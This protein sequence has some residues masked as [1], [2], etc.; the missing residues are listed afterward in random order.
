MAS[1]ENLGTTIGQLKRA[2]IDA[3]MVSDYGGFAG[4]MWTIESDKYT[5]GGKAQVTRPG[6]NGEG[7]GD[8]SG[9]WDWLIGGG[10]DEEFTG[11]FNDIRTRIDDAVDHWTANLPVVSELK[12][13]GDKAHEAMMKLGI[14]PSQTGGTVNATGPIGGYLNLIAEGL[15]EMS[16][17][18]IEAFKGKFLSQL[19]RVIANQY[20]MTVPI[21]GALRAQENL[22]TEA[23]KDIANIVQE[24]LDAMNAVVAGSGPNWELL[25]TVVGVAAKGAG[26]FA[27]GGLKAATEVTGL[28]V[29]VLT[30]PGN[31]NKDSQASA[32][33]T[34]ESVLTALESSVKELSDRIG[35]EEKD[36][37]KNLD[38]N[39]TAFENQLSGYDIN[40]TDATLDV[41][42]A[43]GPGVD[44]VI[45]SKALVKGIT[46]THMP[47][48]ADELKAAASSLW[49]AQTSGTALNRPEGIGV[50][51]GAQVFGLVYKLYESIMNLEWEVRSGA[52]TLDLVIQDFYDADGSSQKALEKHLEKVSEGTVWDPSD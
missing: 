15:D 27:T 18:T 23:R 31:T 42:D 3:Y 21:G 38:D 33:G 47:N 26:I 49:S 1:Y 28:G 46:D 6:E 8:W 12:A 32:D 50:Q 39:A 34:C 4:Q 40:A 10:K 44:I 13:D 25:Y 22:W 41:P 2:A 37:Q 48:V 19:S 16:G 11:V 5:I 24:A 29:T 43:Q 14:T 20:A 51:H 35:Q 17:N 9:D 36:L 52:K 7:G 30:G 45:I